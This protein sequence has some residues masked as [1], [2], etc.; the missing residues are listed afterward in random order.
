MQAT[1]HRTHRND[2]KQAIYNLFAAYVHTVP[3]EQLIKSVELARRDAQLRYV[4]IY[5]AG[6]YCL[7]RAERLEGCPLAPHGIQR[8]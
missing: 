2:K 8:P 1:R 7:G 5:G 6:S 3:L 4:V